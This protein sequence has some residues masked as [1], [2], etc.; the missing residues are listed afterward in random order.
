MRRGAGKHYFSCTNNGRIGRRS[1]GVLVKRSVYC[2]LCDTG[3]ANGSCRLRNIAIN[4]Y[5]SIAIIYNVAPIL[6][7][8][9][10]Y[11][12][13]LQHT[14]VLLRERSRS[15]SRSGS[16]GVGRN[17]ATALGNVVGLYFA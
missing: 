13:C 14:I 9:G 5:R 1:T 11:Y 15:T 17:L 10:I 8:I 12:S 6:L 7:N 2:Y 16:N 3:S 4:R